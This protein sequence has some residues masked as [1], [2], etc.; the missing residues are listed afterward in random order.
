[1]NTVRLIYMAAYEIMLCK[2]LL[3]DIDEFRT[4]LLGLDVQPPPPQ[5]DVVK[6]KIMDLDTEINTYQAGMKRAFEHIDA[7]ARVVHLDGQCQRYLDTLYN[8]TEEHYVTASTLVKE[9]LART[10]DQVA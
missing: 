1:M 4:H 8:C 5:P 6:T 2:T 7:L 9:A 10:F 3:R